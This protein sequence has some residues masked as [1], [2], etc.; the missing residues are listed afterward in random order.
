MPDHRPFRTTIKTCL[1]AHGIKI[2]RVRSREKTKAYP[3]MHPGCNCEDYRP[4]KS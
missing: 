2:H 1:C 4:T 3:C